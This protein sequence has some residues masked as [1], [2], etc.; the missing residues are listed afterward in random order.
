MVKHAAELSAS[1]RTTT[2]TRTSEHDPMSYDALGE[3]LRRGDH[4]NTTGASLA[5]LHV[6]LQLDAFAPEQL[7]AVIRVVHQHLGVPSAG[8]SLSLRLRL[9]HSCTAFATAARG[10]VEG[11][12][13]E[14]VERTSRLLDALVRD[15]DPAVATPAAAAMGALAA[16]SSRITA[17]LGL[18]STPAHARRVIAASA[19]QWALGDRA[20]ASVDRVL[21]GAD[22]FGI[23]EAIRALGTWRTAAPG[24]IDAAI[25][26]LARPDAP[27]EVISA[28]TDYAIAV[29]DEGLR[30]QMLAAL[31]SVGLTRAAEPGL[32]LWSGKRAERAWQLLERARELRIR[33]RVSVTRAAARFLCLVAAPEGVQRLARTHPD[34]SVLAACLD[35]ELNEH[36][37]I[38]PGLGDAGD[39]LFGTR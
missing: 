24:T 31:R 20:D 26:S 36:G 34:V 38:L 14:D 19:V 1:D 18:K 3:A 33:A 12:L 7:P 29:D 22:G 25:V 6:G 5:A 17:F 10:G 11:I 32:A 30:E 23:A 39:R 9:V 8:A 28:A 27:A 37:Y 35:R 13:D 2:H 4:S 16:R 15:R 21:A